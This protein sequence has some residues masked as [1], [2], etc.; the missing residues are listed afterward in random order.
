MIIEPLVFWLV[1][2]LAVLT[3]FGFGWITRNHT[4]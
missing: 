3:G 1:V 4:L 2:G